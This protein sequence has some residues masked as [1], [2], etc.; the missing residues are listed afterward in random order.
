M[1]GLDT[2]K[3]F[4]LETVNDLHDLQTPLNAMKSMTPSFI[5]TKKSTSWLISDQGLQL[6][7]LFMFM[8]DASSWFWSLVIFLVLTISTLAKR[9][10]YL[11]Q[12]GH[13]KTRGIS[14]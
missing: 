11:S 9:N 3:I 13:G 4:L 10:K 6:L 1:G 8:V 5:I 2:I 7:I 14:I 12:S